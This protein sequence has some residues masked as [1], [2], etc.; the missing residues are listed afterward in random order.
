[1]VAH[2]AELHHQVHQAGHTEAG[3]P[4]AKAESCKK[5]LHLEVLL[6]SGVEKALADGEGTIEKDLYFVSQFM[7]TV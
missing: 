6:E 7:F 1:M 4:V 5:F 3:D 2:L